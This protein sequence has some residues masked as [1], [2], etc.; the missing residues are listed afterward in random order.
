MGATAAAAAYLD[1]KLH[2]RQDWHDLR[3]RNRGKNRI[4]ELSMTTSTLAFSPS[5]SPYLH[6]FPWAD[7][8]P[9]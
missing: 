8:M 1:A 9:I 7:S 6:L 2:L 3:A 4:A 5:L